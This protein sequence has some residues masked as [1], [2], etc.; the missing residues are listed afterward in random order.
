MFCVAITERAEGI[1][2]L[3]M[4]YVDSLAELDPKYALKPQVFTH[5]ELIVTLGRP[6]FATMKELTGLVHSSVAAKVESFRRSNPEHEPEAVVVD[7][8]SPYGIFHMLRSSR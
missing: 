4:P 7:F 2:C 6:E 1:T 5:P 8:S 3:Q